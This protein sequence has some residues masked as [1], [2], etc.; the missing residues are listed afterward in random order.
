MDRLFK[1]SGSNPH[2]L[3]EERLYPI[4]GEVKNMFGWQE[5]AF[6]KGKDERFFS[7]QA[8]CGSGK[9]IL[10]IYLATHDIIASGF[11]QKQLFVVPQEHIHKGFVGDGQLQHMSIEQNGKQYNWAIQSCHNFCDGVDRIKSLKNWLLESPNKLA[12]FSKDPQGKIIAGLNAICSHAALAQVWQEI[13]QEYE[14]KGL[15]KIISNLTLRVDEAH[16]ISL[17]F[18]EC[19]NMSHEEWDVINDEITAL[20]KICTYIINSKVSSSKLHLTTA[21]MYRGDARVI[22]SEKVRAKF[23]TYHLDWIEHFEGLGIQNFLLQYEFYTDNP[24]DL[25]AQR[26]LAEPNEKHF[27]VVPRTGSKWRKNG[28]EYRLLLDKLKGLRVLDLV[29]P[30]TQDKNKKLLLAEPKNI[31]SPSQFD[32]VVVCS[33]GREGT[34]WCPC[35]RLHNSACESSVTL[36]VQTIGRPFRRFEGKTKIEIFHYVKKFITPK[37]G[38]SSRELLSDRTNA[39]LFCMQMKDLFDPIL[40]IDDSF[41]LP[42]PKNGSKV[43]PKN[44]VPL[45]WYF[46]DQYENVIKAALETYE[47]LVQDFDSPPKAKDIFESMGEICEEFGISEDHIRREDIQYALACRIIREAAPQAEID[48]VDIAFLRNEGF[49][50]IDEKYEFNR[51]IYFGNC[52]KKDWQLIRN[53]IDN[54]HEKY[55]EV[56]RVG[57]KTILDNRSHPLY[58]WVCKYDRECRK[59]IENYGL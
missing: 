25:I 20:G 42:E 15:D 16:H 19:E 59:H 34:D 46:G 56:K 6:A 23:T 49:D 11:K 18:M 40:I 36:A 33:L 1:V 43:S 13:E 29:T 45:Q 24:V 44:T 7:C 5:K 38:I 50:K 35:S 4:Y 54:W 32:V 2:Y 14:Q 41:E 53:I 3:D 31:K 26:I 51:S 21:T 9:S 58:H 55:Q 28:D 30:S 17:V 52:S 27:V 47:D 39:I 57:F 8:F 37:K 22:L 12:K 10:Q 48:G